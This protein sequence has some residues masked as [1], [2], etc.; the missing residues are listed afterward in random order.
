MERKCGFPVAL[1]WLLSHWEEK[2]DPKQLG[3]AITL[4]NLLQH[5]WLKANFHYY[6]YHRSSL[7]RLPCSNLQ[8]LF[9]EKDNI[10]VDILNVEA[11]QFNTDSM[12][13]I[14]HRYIHPQFVTIFIVIY[15]KVVTTVVN[16][17]FENVVVSRSVTLA[18]SQVTQTFISASLSYVQPPKVS[19]SCVKTLR[20]PVVCLEFYDR[21]LSLQKGANFWVA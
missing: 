13:H 19:Q 12:Q 20:Y 11:I 14:Q 18:F 10:S 1:I 8:L 4:T 16:S 2:D 15:S 6:R 17:S 9:Q 7:T 5:Q 3:L 21:L